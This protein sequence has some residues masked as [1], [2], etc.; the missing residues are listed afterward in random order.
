[1][2]ILAR[3]YPFLA[4]QIRKILRKMTYGEVAE[5]LKAAVC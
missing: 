3:P 1:L 2:G 5:R 4:K